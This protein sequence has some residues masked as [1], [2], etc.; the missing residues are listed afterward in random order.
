MK[1]FTECL[2]DLYDYFILADP[3]TLTCFQ[4][5]HELQ[6]N[7]IEVFTTTDLGEKVIET[8]SSIPMSGIENYPYTIYFNTD[9]SPSIFSKEKNEEQFTRTGFIVLVVSG[10]LSLFTI[11][12]L[13]NWGEMKEKLLTNGFRPIIDIP[14]G[15]HTLT[16][17]GG[18]VLCE[19]GGWDPAL[20]FILTK[21]KEKPQFSAD[22][23]S[24]FTVKARDF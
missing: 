17:K 5:Q 15:W 2:N 6:E 22:M 11:P 24:P 20:E 1:K 19:D 10:K 4:L 14:Q 13:Q 9:D 18:E 21:S 16:V 23:Y 8:G 3:E 12:Y 7:L